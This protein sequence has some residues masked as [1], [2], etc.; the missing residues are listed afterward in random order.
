MKHTREFEDIV[1]LAAASVSNIRQ[2]PGTDWPVAV[3]V[4]K[5]ELVG[6]CTG[7][8]EEKTDGRWFLINLAVPI[9]GRTSAYARQD[10]LQFVPKEKSSEYNSQGKKLVEKLIASDQQLYASL[11]K[12][13]AYLQTLSE[14]GVNIKAYEGSFNK[15]YEKLRKRQEKLQ[16]SKIL[17]VKTSF[18]QKSAVWWAK[19]QI[20]MQTRNIAGLGA[21]PVIAIAV[22][23]A[24][25]VGLSV[26]AYFTFRSDYKESTEDLKISQD[27]ERAL[28]TLEPEKAAAV[29]KD[30]EKQIDT[31]FA[32]GKTAGKFSGTFG[33]IKTLAILV[34]G[35]F[36]G[37]KLLDVVNKKT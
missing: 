25:G 8:Y 37:D 23:A 21:V 18:A 1:V 28:A 30:L 33:T 35:Y 14:K 10:V 29:V 4:K 7:D 24:I 6:T 2:G 16:G 26:T 20:F 19:F 12:I 22:G 32:T 34:L 17:K 5:G 3:Q 36:I 15:L 27:L 11:G 9:G 31:S 13:G